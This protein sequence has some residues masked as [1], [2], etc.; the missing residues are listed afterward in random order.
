MRVAPLSKVTAHDGGLPSKCRFV[1]IV[2]TS[3]RVW[4]HISTGKGKTMDNEKLALI[5]QHHDRLDYLDAW[6]PKEA[7][8]YFERHSWAFEYD[9][10]GNW[11]GEVKNENGWTH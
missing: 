1:A 6:L 3:A 9:Y 10:L 2:A 5:R 7:D 8:A 11:I 4:L